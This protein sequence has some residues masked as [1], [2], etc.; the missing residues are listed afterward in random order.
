MNSNRNP[1]RVTLPHYFDKYGTRHKATCYTLS[2]L[3]SIVVPLSMEYTVWYAR[4]GF[5]VFSFARSG[6]NVL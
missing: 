4:F 1:A 5:N 3:L 2:F 6:F